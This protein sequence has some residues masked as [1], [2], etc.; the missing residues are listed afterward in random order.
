M[1]PTH[2]YRSLTSN[3]DKPDLGIDIIFLLLF[4]RMKLGVG[5]TGN[6]N[7]RNIRAAIATE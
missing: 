7:R 5:F 1:S 2:Y 3:T 6:T 4:E